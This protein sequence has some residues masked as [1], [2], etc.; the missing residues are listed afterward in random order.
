MRDSL[1]IF[2]GDYDLISAQEREVVGGWI[3]TVALLQLH[4]T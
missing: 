2:N 3:K 4:V 1:H